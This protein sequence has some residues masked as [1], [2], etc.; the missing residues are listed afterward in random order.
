[1]SLRYPANPF[2]STLWIDQPD[3]LQRIEALVR[4]RRISAEDERLLRDFHRDGFVRLFLDPATE[5]LDA[6]VD[7]VDRLWRERPHDLLFAYARPVLRRMSSGDPDIDRKPG[8]R[9]AEMHSHSPAARRLYL[10]ARLHAVAR[11]LL[12]EDP[13]AIQS[14]LFEYGSAQGLHRDPVFVQTEK[15][16]HLLA[17]WI[18]LED[19]H[20]DAGPLVYV[21]RSHTLPPFEFAPG[22]Y[23]FDPQ[24]FGEAELQRERAWLEQQMGERGLAAQIFTP[25]K[26][27]VLFWHAGLYHGGHPIRDAARTRRSFV[28][29]YTTRRTHHTNA[30]TM[31][32]TV[33]GQEELRVLGTRRIVQDGRAVGFANPASRRGTQWWAT[34]RNRLSALR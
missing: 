16:G 9:I 4:R 5:P 28:V 6:L 23:R 31:L 10:H 11:L 8:Y 26:G 1:M 17:A 32:E 7:D 30:L 29:H 18:A 20:P 21:P 3:A 34:L 15:A 22:E 27:E 25:R 33:D 14:I 13:V 24:R 12:G 2:A 19:I